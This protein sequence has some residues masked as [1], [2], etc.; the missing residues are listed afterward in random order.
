MPAMIT[1]HNPYTPV[2]HVKEPSSLSEK[3]DDLIFSDVIL[4]GKMHS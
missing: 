1:D 4:P 3:Y 2:G